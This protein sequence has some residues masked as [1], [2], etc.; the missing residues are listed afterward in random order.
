MMMMAGVMAGN[1]RLKSQQVSDGGVHE[2]PVL[3]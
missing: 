1:Y 2:M 3:P